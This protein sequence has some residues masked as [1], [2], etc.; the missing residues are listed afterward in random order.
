MGQYNHIG[1]KLSTQHGFF[2]STP[3]TSS[4]QQVLTESLQIDL[5]VA[6][7]TFMAAASSVPAIA[8]SII[9]ILVAKV[10]D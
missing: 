8:A 4:Y 5:D 3:L 7:A 6:G 2:A 1:L 10:I 9:A